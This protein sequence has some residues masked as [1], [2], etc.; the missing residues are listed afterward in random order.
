VT[1]SGARNR[2]AGGLQVAIALCALATL[3]GCATDGHAQAGP[4]TSVPAVTTITTPIESQV[5]STPAPRTTDT[6]TQPAQTTTAASTVSSTPPAT[7]T[8]APAPTTTCRSLTVRVIRGSASLGQ[9]IAALD[10]V[11]AGTKTCV[12]AGY[13]GVTLLLK[14][15]AIGQPSRPATTV[16]SVRTLKPGDVA[17]S[18]LHDYTSCQAPLSDNVKVTVPGTTKTAVRPAQLRACILRVAKLGAPD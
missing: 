16:P 10:F 11:N 17:E 18:V 5:P 15:K 1:P 3:A 7:H 8:S 13:P 4:T 6:S 12:L 9:E 2:H 14:G